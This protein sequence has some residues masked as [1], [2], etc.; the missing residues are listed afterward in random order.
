M[1]MEKSGLGSPFRIIEL[2]VK[3]H[4]FYSGIPGYAYEH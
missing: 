3:R 2:R 1:L 4:E